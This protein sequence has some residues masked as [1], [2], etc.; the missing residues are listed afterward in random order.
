M[1]YRT[2][3]WLMWA[4]L[5]ATEEDAVEGYGSP[6]ELAD[7]LE[8]FLQPAL[9]QALIPLAEVENL[10]RRLDVFG[11]TSRRWTCARTAWSTGAWW[12]SCWVW[13]SLPTCPARSGRDRLQAALGEG[14]VEPPTDLSEECSSTLDV[15]APSPPPSPR[16]GEEAIGPY[17]ISMAHGADD[18]PGGAALGPRR[19]SLRDADGALPLDIAPLVETVDDLEQA[20]PYL[21]AMLSDATYRPSPR[22][23][24]D[25]QVVMI[26]YSDSSKISGIAASRWALYEAQESMVEVA[27]TRVDLTIFHGRAAPSAVAGLKPREAILAEPWGAVRGRLRSPSKGR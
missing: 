22:G 9:S 5:E 23:R 15:F 11:S 3:L 18:V 27:S 8:L 14:A 13:T 7:D 10:L 6:A 21:Q 4:R 12:A 1:P 20:G 2:L 19:R 17:I 26:G 25:R 16:Y 24:G